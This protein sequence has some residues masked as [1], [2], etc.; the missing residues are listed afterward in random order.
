MGES[1]RN[2]FS[3]VL[4]ISITVAIVLFCAGSAVAKTPG[5]L[6]VEASREGERDVVKRLLAEGASVEAN[7][8]RLG[9]TPLIAAA[10]EG[11]LDVVKLLLEHGADVNARDERFGATPLI[12]A[13]YK[14]HVEIVK[15]LLDHG[16]D[17][18]AK[19]RRYGADA[20]RSARFAR[21]AAVVEFLKAYG[22]R[23]TS[24]PESETGRSD[25]KPASADP[26]ELTEK[27]RELHGA[28]AIGDYEA[29]ARLVKEGARVNARDQEGLTPLIK[30][31]IGGHFSTAKA[32]IRNGADVN[33]T[34]FYY[35]WAP[36]DK[37]L[38]T[39]L[40]K[41]SGALLTD[42]EKKPSANPALKGGITPLDAA[43]RNGHHSVK[44]LLERYGAK[45]TP[46]A[47]E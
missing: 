17:M 3:Y 47:P 31:C 22:D 46:G 2:D 25:R 24:G 28:A 26:R 8:Q 11:R 35:S 29:A 6:L 44:W 13:A 39:C 45:E 42:K 34:A 27:D 33:A 18:F 15:I 36:L 9:A 20:I 16:A 12:A 41:V 23:A 4:V 1:N 21:N 40:T 43:K 32:L 38:D 14:G 7:H 5:E 30:A 37:A 19:D 10:Y